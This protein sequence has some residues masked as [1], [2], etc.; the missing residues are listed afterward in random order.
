[1]SSKEVTKLLNLSA[2]GLAKISWANYEYDFK[3]QIGTKDYRCPS[4][5]AEFLSPRISNLRKTDCTIQEFKIETDDSEKCFECFLSLGFGSSVCLN[6]E[7][8]LIFENLSVELGAEE[9]YEQLF[10]EFEVEINP[11]N[12]CHRLKH[13][14][15][16]NCPCEREIAFAASHFTNIDSTSIE[17][18]SV[19]LLFQILKHHSLIIQS[20]DWLFDIILSLIS[21]NQDYFSLLELIGYEYLSKSSIESFI[22][23]ISESFEFLTYSIWQNLR[24]RLISGRNVSTS[25]RVIQKTFKFREDSRF[26]GI[27]S[28]LTPADGRNVSD[29]NI[30]SVKSSG[31]D[32]NR[33]AKN[34]ADLKNLTLTATNN[35]PNSWISYD[36]Q[37]MEVK[38]SHYS[39]HSRIDCESDHLTNWTLE[40]SLDEKNWITFDVQNGCRSLIGCNRSA[41][42][43]T[44]GSEFVR[45]VRIRQ[46][47]KSSNGSGHL[48]LLKFELFG[49]LRYF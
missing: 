47:G 8:Y 23:L 46:H 30:V 31:V 44:S 15:R 6:R 39:L 36:F 35:E 16:L 5:V 26:D 13:L 3:F 29:C 34:A 27:I 37:K 7:D 28:F 42:F 24:S 21:K 2:K 12:V 1:M 9:F 40:G 25:R 17:Q 14:E 4:F 45:F 43:E 11:Q 19:S 10:A 49:V 20:E 41:P 33:Q 38:V 22:N 32:R 18:L 48:T